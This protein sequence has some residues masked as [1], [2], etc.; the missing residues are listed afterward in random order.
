MEQNLQTVQESLKT[1]GLPSAAA[2]EFAFFPTEKGVIKVHLG[3][4]NQHFSR[5]VCSRGGKTS[6]PTFLTEFRRETP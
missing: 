2:E 4:N 6:Q 1:Q 3:F 5:T